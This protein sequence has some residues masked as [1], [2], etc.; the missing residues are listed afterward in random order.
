MGTVLCFLI[1]EMADFELTFVSHLLA[2]NGKKTITTIAYEKETVTSRAGI[3]YSPHL[4]VQDALALPDIQGLIIPGG[5]KY[6]HR[7]EMGRLIQKVYHGNG[8][9]GAICAGTKYLAKEGILT[10]HAY[11]TTSSIE[12]P[13]PADTFIKKTVV[14][15]KNVITALNNAFVDFA[16]E[17]CDWFH[18]FG[19]PHEKA[20]VTKYYKGM[21]V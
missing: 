5:W 17:I 9:L 7:D 6:E 19:T 21:T 18:L 8:V 11:T 15:D 1:D 14:R 20:M 16:I 4:T 10:G 3:A 12:P 13:F 2:F